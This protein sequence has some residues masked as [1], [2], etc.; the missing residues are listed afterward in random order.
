MCYWLGE[1]V[2]SYNRLYQSY[3]SEVRL[4]ISLYSDITTP[5]IT[6][7]LSLRITGGTLEYRGSHHP[8]KG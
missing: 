2:R 4:F 5:S 7:I 1:Q 6:T 8:E 3:L